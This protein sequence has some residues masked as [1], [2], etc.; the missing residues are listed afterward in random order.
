[1][2]PAAE[3]DNPASHGAGQR[4]PA[5]WISVSVKRPDVRQL[6]VEYLCVT[7]L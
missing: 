6:L 3:L 7:S 2:Q 1:L 4:Q 5:D